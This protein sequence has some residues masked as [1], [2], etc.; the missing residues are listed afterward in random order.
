MTQPRV[1]G[2]PCFFRIFPFLSANA[3]LVAAEGRVG[4]PRF[5]HDV[6]A[7]RFTIHYSLSTIYQPVGLLSYKH[8]GGSSNKISRIPE[9]A[10]DY[11]YLNHQWHESHEWDRRRGADA[12][13]RADYRLQATG[14]CSLNREPRQRREKTKAGGRGQQ[15]ARGSLADNRGLTTAL[16][17]Q[18]SQITPISC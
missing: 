2:A 18:I 11:C 9:P 10:T 8:L 16:H 4:P 1:A 15:A 17:P 5:T 14:Y 7:L 12:A 6:E 3:V 13:G